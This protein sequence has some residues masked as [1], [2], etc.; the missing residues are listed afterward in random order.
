MLNIKKQP[1]SFHQN[2]KCQILFDKKVF[3]SHSVVNFKFKNLLNY[4]NMSVQYN[5]IF[6]AGK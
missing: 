6:H 4:A 3:C 2:F 5:A 1:N